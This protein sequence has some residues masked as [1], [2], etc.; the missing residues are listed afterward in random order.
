MATPP[1]SPSPQGRRAVRSG[2]YGFRE[3]RRPL[4]PWE[5]AAWTPLKASGG[6]GAPDS[7]APSEPPTRLPRRVRRRTRTLSLGLALSITSH[8]PDEH[9]CS[10]HSDPC[11]GRTWISRGRSRTFVGPW[12]C[13]PRVRQVSPGTT[14]CSCWS[15]RPNSPRERRRR[16]DVGAG[17]MGVS[18][19]GCGQPFAAPPLPR[20]PGTI[21][22][23]REPLPSSSLRRTW[24]S[25]G[26]VGLWRR[27][28]RHEPGLVLH[29]G[30]W[31]G[32][33]VSSP[34]DCLPRWPYS[35]STCL[36]TVA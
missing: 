4:L 32:V 11:V 21:R 5:L 15:S 36:S 27:P 9:T 14:R 26:R 25:Q 34:S 22:L 24:S 1:P 29:R 10:L 16:P 35:R 7:P 17:V 30:F 3:R 18:P 12:P 19:M 23:T 13:C 33:V 20:Q 2:S 31:G 8:L 6:P 28:P